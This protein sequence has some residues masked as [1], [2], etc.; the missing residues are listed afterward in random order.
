MLF[1]ISCTFQIQNFGDKIIEVLTLH[2]KSFSCS[3]LAARFIYNTKPI[4]TYV[5]DCR[6]LR[7]PN[8]VEFYGLV[9]LSSKN[10]LGLVM[11]LCETDLEAYSERHIHTRANK[12]P[13]VSVSMVH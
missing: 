6:E 10:K 3:Q 8:V 12:Q 4:Y 1:S 2:Y 9:N 13:Q 11:Q 7:H 5:T